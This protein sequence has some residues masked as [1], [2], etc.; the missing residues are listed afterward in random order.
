M[1]TNAFFDNVFD[2][3]TVRSGFTQGDFFGLFSSPGSRS[4][5]VIAPEPVRGGIR[6]SYRF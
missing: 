1:S 3:D 2:D 6:A 4:Y 5:V